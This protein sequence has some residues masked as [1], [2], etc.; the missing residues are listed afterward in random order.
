MFAAFQQVMACQHKCI[1]YPLAL[2]L[3][4]I[5]LAKLTGESKLNEVS[6]KVRL[7][8]TIVDP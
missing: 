5:V 2:I 6:Q 8:R 3:M 1:R 4:L 7:R